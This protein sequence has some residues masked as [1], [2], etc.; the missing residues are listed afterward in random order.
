[1]TFGPKEH[2][3]SDWLQENARITWLEHPEPWLLETELIKTLSLP[4][5]LD[6]NES[7]PFYPT[8]SSLRAQARSH[9]RLLPILHPSHPDHS[10]KSST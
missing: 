4:L 7:H 10:T 8:L 5:N 9:A 3:L 6:Q 2:I 1:M